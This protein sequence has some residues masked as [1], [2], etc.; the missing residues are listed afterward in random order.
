MHS[1]ET[2]LFQHFAVITKVKNIKF[3][4]AYNFKMLTE[5]KILHKC[6]LLHL[7]SYSLLTQAKRSEIADDSRVGNLRH[8][9]LK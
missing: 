9:K 4:P 1:V 8:R 7:Y 3:S 5:H 6:R 2:K